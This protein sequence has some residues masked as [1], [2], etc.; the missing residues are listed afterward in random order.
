MG[1]LFLYIV[2]NKKNLFVNKIAFFKKIEKETISKL[3]FINFK[4]L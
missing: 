2:L 3:C 1:E 4:N